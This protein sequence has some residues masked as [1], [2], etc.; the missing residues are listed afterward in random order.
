MINIRGIGIGK[1]FVVIFGPSSNLNYRR[2][3]RIIWSILGYSTKQSIKKKIERYHLSFDGCGLGASVG[4]A[5]AMFGERMGFSN[6]IRRDSYSYLSASSGSIVLLIPRI[7]TVEMEECG[8]TD[9]RRSVREVDNGSGVQGQGGS[10]SVTA[11]DVVD[12]LSGGIEVR[13]EI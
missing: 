7:R 12:A 11:G 4:S 3:R 6:T 2:R 1:V 9:A 8:C 13:E 10:V 5:G